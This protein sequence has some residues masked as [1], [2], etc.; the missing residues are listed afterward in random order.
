[1]SNTKSSEPPRPPAEAFVIPGRETFLKALDLDL[2]E[3]ADVKAALETG[4]VA[5]AGSAYVRHFRTCDLSSTLL[6][7]WDSLPQDPS[8]ENPI[9]ED[10]LRG[11]LYDGYNY[12]D[13]PQEGIDWYD[14]PL[15]CLPRFPIFPAL[16]ASWHHKQDDRYPRFVIDHALEYMAAYSIQDFAGKH[17]NEG[18]RNHYL[19]G[20]PTWW[21]LCPNRLEAWSSALA[22]LRRSPSV[23][24]EEILLSL[25]RMLQ[26]IRYFIT[27][28]PFWL[29]RRHNV[30]S[31][32][33][34]VFGILTR[35]FQ[36]FSEAA[37]W[38]EMDAEWLAEYIDG[39]FY[40]DGLFKELTLGYSS[41]VTAQT[42]RIASDLFGEPPIQERSGQLAAM[43][44]A[45]V[46]LAKPTGPV[47]SFGDGPGRTLGIVWCEELVKQIGVPWLSEISDAV[48][49][50][51]PPVGPGLPP[52]NIGPEEWPDFSLTSPPFTEW[53]PA[54]EPAWGGYYAMRSDWSADARYLM[55]DGGPWGT[56][57]RH[58]DKLSFELAAYGADFITDPGNTQY[59]NNEPDARISMLN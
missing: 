40:P 17:S 38:R 43:V 36:D 14:C 35:V 39:G 2:P 22:L 10:C 9:A 51:K 28:V 25:H 48:Q 11:R 13:I 55:V 57:H 23:T 58:M 6:T 27:Q 24:D 20:P 31:F 34:R 46:G 15:F 42:S 44:G 19:V 12:Y 56:T 54:G 29:G 49:S 47:P 1:M 21:C 5:E 45:M 37:R 7:D 26:E 3:L 30:A 33:I 50:I 41:S 16:V 18:Y 59:A 32:T 4:D 8:Y 52:R 53:P